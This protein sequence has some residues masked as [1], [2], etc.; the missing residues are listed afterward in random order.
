MFISSNKIYKKINKKFLKFET[1]NMTPNIQILWHKAKDTL[2][3]DIFK[4]KYIDFTSGIFVTNIGH[5]NKYLLNE[6]IKTLKSGVA[7]S[8]NY[9]NVPREKYIVQLI[10]FINKKKLK[11]C[12]LVSSGT[13]ATETALKLIRT[14]GNTINKEKTGVICING[15]W[16]GR[17]VGSQMLSGKNKQ[18]EWIGYYDKKI[19]HIDFPYPWLVKSNKNYLK[20]F[21]KKSLVRTF[22]KNYNFKKNISGILL[23]TFQGWGAVFYP[24]HYVKEIARF[25]KKNNILL[26]F[27]E[28]QS[29]FGRTGK[30]FGFE[31]Y[32]V[33]PDLICCGKGMGSGF[34][35][36]GV[37]TSKK[38][39]ENKFVTGLSSTHSANPL[40]CTAGY[41]TIN[42]INKKK[43]VLRSKNLGS[44]FHKKLNSLNKK[45]NTI[46]AATLGKGLIGSVIFKDA[47]GL[48][49]KNIA[50]MFSLE[51]L[52]NKLLVCNTG[53]ES[54]KLGPPL[55]INLKVLLKSIN[56]IDFS[57]NNIIKKIS[58]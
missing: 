31:H 35:L 23:E 46:I 28:M 1:S 17:T 10:K 42:F 40:A 56:I 20:V 2:I 48:K 58:R 16:H 52:N 27:D 49:A 30:K 47:Y 19:F 13:E 9:Y 29:G 7:H 53:R 8:Y 22:G 51:C 57:L 39:M 54:V 50:D 33:S 11:K 55:T 38:I 6:I 43:L 12:H 36:S 14:Y 5:N 45:Y 25:C 21:L 3:T 37:V 18:S 15:N 26:C 32:D 4:K 44:I 34:P 24:K 41:A